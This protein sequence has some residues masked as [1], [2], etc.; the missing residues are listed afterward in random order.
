MTNPDYDGDGRDTEV[1]SIC[2]ENYRKR[3]DSIVVDLFQGQYKSTIICQ[4]CSKV[5]VTFDPF[6]YLSLPMPGPERVWIIQYISSINPGKLPMKTLVKLPENRSSPAEILKVLSGRLRIA[7]NMLVLAELTF[8]FRFERIF[9][10]LD[11]TTRI[12]SEAVL[13]VYDTNVSTSGYKVLS[14]S[15][16]EIL[17]DI[18][19]FSDPEWAVLPA[20]YCAAG[21]E[22]SK[23]GMCNQSPSEIGPKTTLMRC[24]RCFHI[25]YCSEKCQKEHYKA[26][27][28]NC[29]ARRIPI[30]PPRLVVVP[31][32]TTTPTELLSNVFS[33]LA[34]YFKAKKNNLIKCSYR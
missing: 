30:G 10:S 22:A 32:A 6:M 4:S 15:F 16:S 5:S 1:A 34:Y 23:C 9:D 21:A 13:A 27:K 29:F 3:N 12:D 20:Y 8:S 28:P 26:H 31:R 14:H 33:Y 25:S 24:S 19:R 11:T 7:V 17:R 2:W 18:K